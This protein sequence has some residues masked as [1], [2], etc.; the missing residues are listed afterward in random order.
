MGA[1]N[2]HPTKNIKIQVSK[3][4]PLVFYQKDSFTTIQTKFN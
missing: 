2:L 4:H 1:V 3:L